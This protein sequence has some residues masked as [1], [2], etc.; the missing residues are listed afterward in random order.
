MNQLTLIRSTTVSNLA[1]VISYFRTSLSGRR[2]AD[3]VG[4]DA[5]SSDT[6]QVTEILRNVRVLLE[7]P[8]GVEENHAVVGR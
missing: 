2:T 6:I 3:I 7:Q 1:A 4:A 8:R 5:G